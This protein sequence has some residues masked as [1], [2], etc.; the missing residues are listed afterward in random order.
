MDARFLRTR[1][2]LGA[3]AM[4]RL[5]KAH[6]CVLGL[7][8]VGSWCAEALARSGVGELTLMDQDQVEPSN[9]NRQAEALESTLGLP[10]AEAMAQR[11]LAVNPACRVHPVQGRYEVETREDFFAQRYDY[12]VDAI[13]LVSCKLDLIETALRRGVP[14]ISA[15]GTGNKLDASLLRVSDLSKTE[16]CP[17]A[18]VVRKELRNRGILHHK[19]VWSPE[20]ARKADQPE[21]PPPGRRSVPASVVWVPASAGLLLAGEVVMDLTGVR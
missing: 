4:E 17:L 5:E 11:V 16:G 7:G 15:L 10:K 21:A 14:I 1:M 18:R 8:G 3:D 12:I 2:L 13:D 20:E 9:L 6:V 19:V